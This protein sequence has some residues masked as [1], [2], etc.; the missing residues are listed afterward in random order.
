[1]KISS[2]VLCGGGA[3]S[4]AVPLFLNHRISSLHI[5]SC[6]ISGNI[7]SPLPSSHSNCSVFPL[8]ASFSSFPVADHVSFVKDVA[9]TQ[10]PQHLSQLLSILK[11]RGNTI[12]HYHHVIKCESVW[13]EIWN[14]SSRVWYFLGDLFFVFHGLCITGDT[15]ISPAAKQGLFPLA[16]PLSQNSSGMGLP[17]KSF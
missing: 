11:T 12:P 16:I 9:A 6:S 13:Y 5:S 17:V 2:G 10:P 7:T 4:N 1:M 8:F 14:A 15:I 3:R